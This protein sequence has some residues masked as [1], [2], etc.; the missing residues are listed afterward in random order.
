MAAV[1]IVGAYVAVVALWWFVFRTTKEPDRPDPPGT[2]R[3]AHP[4]SPS[5]GERSSR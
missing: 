1:V 3:S 5:D 4:V 2:T